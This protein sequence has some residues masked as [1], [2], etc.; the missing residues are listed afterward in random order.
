MVGD[1]LSDR[2]Q[3]RTGG[4]MMANW[5]S[6]PSWDD[7]KDLLELWQAH[8]PLPDVGLR[9]GG[10]FAALIAV[11][12]WGYMASKAEHRKTETEGKK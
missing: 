2:P 1:A 7:R 4:E 9:E 12:D 11:A 5:D 10:I 3:D 8:A 6:R